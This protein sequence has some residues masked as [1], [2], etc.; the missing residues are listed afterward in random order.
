MH[1]SNHNVICF[2]GLHTIYCNILSV[3]CWCICGAG[4]QV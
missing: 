4:Q 2:L 3:I 1:I